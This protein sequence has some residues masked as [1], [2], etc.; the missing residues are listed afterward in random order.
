M[1]M[2]IKITHLL[3]SYITKQPAGADCPFTNKL[4]FSKRACVLFWF[5]CAQWFFIR[6]P[7]CRLRILYCFFWGDVLPVFGIA[8]V[9][10]F[11]SSSIGWCLT[12]R[13][14]ISRHERSPYLYLSVG[15]TP[16]ETNNFME[17]KMK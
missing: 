16:T 13:N 10:R 7:D 17:Q 5:F 6:F 12:K 9:D 1:E 2:F 8:V 4:V 15:E 3:F 14:Q 11:F